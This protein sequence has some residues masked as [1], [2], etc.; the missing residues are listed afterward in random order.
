MLLRSIPR[1]TR[2]LICRAFAAFLAAA[3]LSGCAAL[4][5]LN[6]ATEPRAVYELQIPDALPAHSGPVRAR[7]VI[8]EQPTTSGALETER[9]MIRPNR[10][11]A[12][13][14]PGVQ[15][16]EATPLALQTLMVRTLDA[17]GTF[18]YVGRRPLGPGGDFAIVS[19]LVD[20]QAELGPEGEGA[21]VAVRLIA[22][23]VRENGVRVVATR[24]FSARRPAASLQAADIVLALDA[25]MAQ[26]LKDFAEWALASIR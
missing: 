1:M 25:A 13:Y 12:A 15:W 24:V 16:S 8:V 2:R 19:E 9:I 18:Q 14:L 6:D 4:G 10:L 7:D 20:F 23:I 21:E 11:E 5:A 26:V 17:T 3:T 22:R